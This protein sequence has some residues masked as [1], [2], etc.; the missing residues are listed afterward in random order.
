M[1]DLPVTPLTHGDG[2]SRADGVGD[3]D[4]DGV[5]SASLPSFAPTHASAMPGDLDD[6]KEPEEL[7]ITPQW[8]GSAAVGGRR[9]RST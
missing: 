7:I 8:T 2:A 9:K 1:A 4:D 6:F 3:D 5:A